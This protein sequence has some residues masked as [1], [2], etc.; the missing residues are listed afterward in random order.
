MLIGVGSRDSLA[1]DRFQLEFTKFQ[2]T[3]NILNFR[4]QRVAKSYEFCIMSSNFQKAIG[5]STI[6]S[7]TIHCNIS[8]RQMLQVCSK[9][10]FQS[11]G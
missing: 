4:I 5:G 3:A 9:T 2:S 8:S 7:I 6:A 1:P 10:D 11:I